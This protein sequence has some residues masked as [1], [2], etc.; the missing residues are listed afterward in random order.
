MFLYTFLGRCVEF[1]I[2]MALALLILKTNEADRK[3]PIFTL[4][5]LF[6]IAGSIGIMASLPL[7][8]IEYGLYH[9]VGIITNNLVL[10]IGIAFFYFGVIKERSLIRKFLSSAT[11]QLLGKS[12]YIFYLIH[13]GVIANFT[14]LWTRSAVDA[15]YN[16]LDTNGFDWLSEHLND[17]VLFIAI[18]FIVL[19]LVSILL[20]K[21]I[22]EP[23]NLYIRKSRLLENKMA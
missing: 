21:T 19:N 10:P 16:W 23:V 5:G 2:G 3:Y 8:G 22:E 4:L 17:S 11:M 1:F 14:K 18:V 13:I 15:F 12:S 9:P 20:Y 7:D 6:G